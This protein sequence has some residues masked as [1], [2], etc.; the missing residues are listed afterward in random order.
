MG[1]R[2]GRMGFSEERRRRKLLLSSLQWLVEGLNLNPK[3]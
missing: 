3:P 1:V 2:G